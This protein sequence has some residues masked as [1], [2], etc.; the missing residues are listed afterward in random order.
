MAGSNMVEHKLRLL[1]ETELDEKQKQQ[2]GKQ[3]KTILEGAAIGFDEAETK[4]NLTPIIRMIQK[5][6]DKAEMKFDADKLLG[7]PS[8][9]A[10]QSIADITAEEFQ[11]AFDR[12]LSKSGGI[13]IDFGNIDLSGMTEPLERVAGELA[14]ISQKIANDT[15]KS[16]DDIEASIKRLNKV[17][18]KKITTKFI[19]DGV[20]KKVTK[21]VSQV[22]QTVGT[23][24]KT[25]ESVNNPKSLN[26]EKAA[27][28]ALERARDKYNESVT[29]GDPWEIQYQYL[30]SFVSKYEAM[31]KKIK[32]VMDANHSE[33]KELYDVLY[34]KAGAAKISLE[35]FVDVSRGNELSEYK[36]QP[37]ARESTLKKIEQTLKGGISVKDGSGDNGDNPTM[38][39]P[40][41]TTVSSQVSGDDNSGKKLNTKVDVAAKNKNVKTEKNVVDP[42]KQINTVT[43]NA[44][45]AAKQASK[46]IVESVVEPVFTE[47]EKKIFALIDVAKNKTT[48]KWE[49]VS[50]V[51]QEPLIVE[52]LESHIPSFSDLDEDTQFDITADIQ[53]LSNGLMDIKEASKNISKVLNVDDILIP[54]S[55]DVSNAERIADAAESKS[56]ADESS[57]DAH[58]EDLGLMQ[59]MEKFQDSFEKTDRKKEALS[60]VNTKTGDMS[61]LVVGDTHG[62]SMDAGTSRKMSE[63]GYDM[64]VHSHSW[65]TAAP[66]VEDFEEWINQLEYIKK[67]GIRAGEELLAF[68][69]SKLDPTQLQE[70]LKKYKDLDEDISSQVMSMSLDD[71]LGKFGS[72]QGMQEAVQVMLRQ[73]L[74]EVL[75]NIPGVMKSIKMPELPVESIYS[76][77]QQKNKSSNTRSIDEV[78]ASANKEAQELI[79][80]YAIMAK[81]ADKL[82]DDEY[83]RFIKMGDR[84]EEVAPDVFLAPA[85]QLQSFGEKLINE[86]GSVKTD[87]DQHKQNAGAEVK[88]SI[89]TEELKGLLNAITYN[90]KVVQDADAT[91]GSKVSIDAEGLKNALNAITYN[92][93]V[94]RDVA[95]E[96]NKVSIDEAALESVLNRI[97]YDVKIVHDDAD[98]T[99]N[100]IA[101]DEGALESTLSKV[102]ANVLNQPTQQND[103]E[104]AEKRWALESTLQSVNEVLD[105][106]QTNTAKFGTI[107]ISNV[108]AIAGTTLE[109]KLAEIKSVLESIDNKIAKGGVIATRG[110]VKQANA[111]PVESDVRVQATRSNMMKSLISDYKM[112][113]K[114]AA[115]FASEGNLETQAMLE[116]L[117]EE[118]GRKRK[119]LN[120]TMEENKSLRDKY[121]IAFDAEKRLLDAAKAQKA[122]ND[123]NKMD[124][125][126]SE[127]AWKKQ[128]KDAQRATGVNAATSTANAG[129]QTVLRAI[130]ADG[131]SKD[132]ENKAKELSNNI[133]TL[134]ELRDEIDKKGDQ[135]SEEDRDNLS[136]QIVK[137]KEL[138][139]EVDGYLKL[140]EKYSGE[141]ATQFDDVDTSNFGA[142]GTNQYW[143]NITAAIKN[144]SDGRVT[145]KGMN[146]DT[147]ELTGTTKIAANTFAQWSATVD[148]IT[149]KLSI[150][151]TGI[152][153]TETL[154]EQI[155]RK[156]KEIFTYF[157]G[158]SI[159]FKAFNELKRGIQYIKEID[160]ALTELKKVTD[161]TEEAYDRFL[162]TAAKTGARLGATISAVTEA[163]A[164][165]AKL[166]YDMVTATEMAEAAI[167]YKNVGDNIA[168]TE[169]AADSIISTLKGF[170]MEASEAMAIVD[171]FNEVGNRFAI[172]SQGIGEALRLSASALNEG[173]NSLDES[174]AMITA[175]NEVVG[176]MPRSHSNMV[177]RSDLKR[178]NS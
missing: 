132:I 39:S 25:L 2:V 165:F 103:S 15:K 61:D 43:E 109:G 172:T 136:R 148:P 171:R 173:G 116:N 29:K 83:D 8:Q 14:D 175:A 90:V 144:A 24:E 146:A 71:K 157:S 104:Q 40:K 106:I 153:K 55:K 17:K 155:T 120:I 154:I 7:M 169:D 73:G 100:K 74:E 31:T 1:I 49:N 44:A 114:L 46:E 11:T 77:P 82:S 170:G 174:I 105:N 30:V 16:V 51:Q 45:N 22:E 6:F 62:V 131:V 111:Q 53:D 118:I 141:G 161:E 13:K 159:I 89:D 143:N 128:V 108:D 87:A 47:F 60:F 149:G 85:S 34:P 54:T 129:D 42:T 138:K 65:K 76:E 156:T 96:G 123:Q 142:L 80:N 178:G 26:T 140:H 91:N 166:G 84:L 56:I 9:K 66:S 97:V 121:S 99:A 63:A 23:I 133:K 81:N 124:A 64:E 137:V 176:F 50:V 67:F 101:L 12:A 5:L 3:L 158:S 58:R 57:V 32:P 21:E 92:V 163:T 28:K 48:R 69:F 68:D 119:S 41:P 122:I 112:M 10:L 75:Q 36:N 38:E 160:L 20:E 37:W 18:P 52:A 151:R 79:K 78:F 35:H 27:A 110:A 19:E 164:T 135:A 167:V 59:A 162:E 127:A 70:I 33:F 150:L 72:Y 86:A 117:K 88:A 93:K 147:G 94:V 4:K 102:F 98:K 168:S 126:E 113:G 139:T 115:Q 145:I 125:K 152:K 130:G 177:T 95:T 107:E 134:R